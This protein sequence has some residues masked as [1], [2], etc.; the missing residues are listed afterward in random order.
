MVLNLK[1]RSTDEIDDARIKKDLKVKFDGSEISWEKHPEIEYGDDD[2]NQLQYHK[3]ID[4]IWNK[5]LFNTVYSGLPITCASPPIST[6][7]GS[8]RKVS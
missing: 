4:L 1:N 7:R 2:K 5:G 8:G 6:R 3:V